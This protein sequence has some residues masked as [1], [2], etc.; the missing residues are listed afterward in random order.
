MPRI[1]NGVIRIS[2]SEIGVTLTFTMPGYPGWVVTRQ[3]LPEALNAL[4]AHLETSPAWSRPTG[5]A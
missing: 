2:V 5:Q 1:K 3:S 4:A